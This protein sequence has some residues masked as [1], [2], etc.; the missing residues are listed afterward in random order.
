MLVNE[1]RVVVDAQVHS[2]SEQAALSEPL[3]RLDGAQTQEVLLD[4]GFNTYETLECALKKDISVLCPERAEDAPGDEPGAGRFALRH[5]RYVEDG[6]YYLCPTESDCIRVAAQGNPEAGRRA[7]VQYHDRL[8]SV[9]APCAVHRGH[10]AHDPAHC[11]PGARRRYARSWPSRG[12]TRVCPAQGDG[13][14][15]VLGAARTSGPESIPPP[16]VCAG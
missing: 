11:R 12:P 10:A 9:R 14:T 6:D 16:R 1:A 7:Y 4:A 5:F 2:T 15:G 13:R 3:G 8:R